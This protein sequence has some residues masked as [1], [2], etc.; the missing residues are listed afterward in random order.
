MSMTA[1]RE[2]PSQQV[3]TLQ[4]GQEGLAVEGYKHKPPGQWSRERKEGPRCL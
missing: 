2:S 3:G 1:A 4:Q